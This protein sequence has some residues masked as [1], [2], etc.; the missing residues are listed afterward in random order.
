M[1]TSAVPMLTSIVMMDHTKTPYQKAV[2]TTVLVIVAYVVVNARRLLNDI[3]GFINSLFP[4]QK[5]RGTLLYSYYVAVDKNSAKMMESDFNRIKTETFAILRNV[6]YN[7]SRR[8]GEWSSHD[9]RIIACNSAYRALPIFLVVPVTSKYIRVNDD[10]EI[11]VKITCEDVIGQHDSNSTPITTP[12]VN[13]Y[14]YTF[15]SYDDVYTVDDYIRECTQTFLREEFSN[16]LKTPHIFLYDLPIEKKTGWRILDFTSTKTFDSMF[17]EHKTGLIRRI[18]DFA[19]SKPQYERLSIPYTL[20]FLFHGGPGTGKTSVIKAI[21]NLTGRHPVV[22]PTKNIDT[23]DDLKSIFYSEKIGG[24][25]VPNDKRLYV[26]EEIDCGHWRDMIMSRA[27]KTERENERHREMKEMMVMNQRRY[28][29]D[30]PVKQSDDASLISAPAKH[31]CNMSL[32]EFLEFMDGVVELPGRMI[33]FTTNCIDVLDPAI[34]RPGRIDHVVEFKRMRRVDVCD[35]YRRW[36]DR[37]VPDDVREH[38]LPDETFTQ[39]ELGNIFIT[40]EMGHIHT[41]ISS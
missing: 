19:V 5:K 24:H 27:L 3:R 4:N 13:K 41:R 28:S 7:V 12:N 20:S 10:H 35:M 11:Y 26:F 6:E 31:M 2:Y 34:I 16:K 17:F 14:T 15:V 30:A 29:G 38:M 33:I 21:A 37:D 25:I 22:I 23:V 8:T 40:R 32:G 18:D 1:D 39:A 36:F 9:V